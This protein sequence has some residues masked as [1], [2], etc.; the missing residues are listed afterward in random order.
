M[1]LLLVFIYSNYKGNQLIGSKA[2]Q[3][4][5]GF[6]ITKPNFLALQEQVEKEIQATARM[7]YD[8]IAEGSVGI[9]NIIKL[10]EEPT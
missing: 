8:R 6:L 7:P 9:I 3:V 4:E 1:T 2:I 5:P 10:D